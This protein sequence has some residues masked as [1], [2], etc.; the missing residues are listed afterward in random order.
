MPLAPAALPLSRLILATLLLAAPTAALLVALCWD[1]GVS[2]GEALLGLL[3]VCGA[4]ALLIRP[5]L[6][7]L[8]ALRG[9]VEVMVRNEE[10]APLVRSVNPL[11]TGLWLAIMRLVRAWRVSLAQGSAE[12][13][14][15]QAVLAALPD[16][17]VLLDQRRE[18]VRT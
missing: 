1:G 14:A 5:L 8:A 12:L 9:A 3:A 15:A 11:V 7:G 16:P 18:V 2:V 4:I 17:L 13:A 10:A 6:E